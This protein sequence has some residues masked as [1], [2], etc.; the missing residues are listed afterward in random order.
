MN[1]NVNGANVAQF[2]Y[3]AGVFKAINYGSAGAGGGG[4]GW[5]F[6]SVNYPTPGAGA[7]GQNGYVYIYWTKN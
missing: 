4:G 2:E 5:S 6:D 7:K 1:N 3:P